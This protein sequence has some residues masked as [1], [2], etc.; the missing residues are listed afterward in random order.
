MLLEGRER[1]SRAGA[2]VGALKLRYTG[3]P[4]VAPPLLHLP[5]VDRKR[6]SFTLALTITSRP[7]LS[8]RNGYVKRR[9]S[10]AG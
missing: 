7:T 5:L 9:S 8:P 6:G 3:E 2:L 4:F 1:K 10:T